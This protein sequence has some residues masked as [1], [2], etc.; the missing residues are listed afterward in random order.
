L[1]PSWFLAGM[2]TMVAMEIFRLRQTEPIAWI[3]CDYAGRIAALALLAA[4]PAARAVAF[5]CEQSKIGLREV[6]LWIVGIVAFDRIVDHAL[7]EYVN[8]AVPGTR[9]G[10]IP[11]AHGW[12]YAVDL[13]GGLVLVAY[14]EEV[15]FRRCARALLRNSFGD[16]P[17]MIIA[18]A[19]LFASYHWWTGFGNIVAT[20]SFGIVAMLFYRRD[21][22]VLPLVLAH[23]IC[24]VYNFS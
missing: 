3:G 2:A 13:S 15:I 18:A 1:V 10:E 23:Y 6:T 12:L 20:L 19:L 14:S 17:A 7:A 4:I 11:R 21:G 5:P 8:A 22:T 9:V 16:G 24:D